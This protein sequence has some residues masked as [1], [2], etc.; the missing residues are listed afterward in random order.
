MPKRPI[1][2]LDERAYNWR[3]KFSLAAVLELL[4]AFRFGILSTMLTLIL[5]F[6]LCYKRKSPHQ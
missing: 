1:V 3:M 2:I 5:I 6:T 4:T